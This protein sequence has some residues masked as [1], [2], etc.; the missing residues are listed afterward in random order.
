MKFLFPSSVN[1]NWV[2]V[3]EIIDACFGFRD[4]GELKPERAETTLRTIGDLII[5]SWNLQ[6]YK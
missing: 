6:L 5:Y 3:S 2:S 1:N 4:F